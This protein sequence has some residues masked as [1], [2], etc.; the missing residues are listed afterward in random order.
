MGEQLSTDTILACLLPLSLFM[1]GLAWLGKPSL[2]FQGVL[3]IIKG[4]RPVAFGHYFSL[5]RAVVSYDQYLDMSAAELA[6]MRNSYGKLG[7]VHK[8]VGYELGYPRKLDKLKATFEANEKVTRG[9]GKCAR[10]AFPELRKSRITGDGDLARVR[11]TLKHFI[12]DWSAEGAS[13]REIIFQPILNALRQVEGDQRV[14]A[15]VLVPGG[16]LCRLAWDIS[17]LGFDTT[18][19]EMSYFMTLAFRFLCSPSYTSRTDQHILHPYSYWF[20]HQRDTEKVLRG[21]SFPDSIP[22]LSS[23]MQLVEG[24]FLEHRAPAGGYDYVVTLFFIDTSLNVIST[25]E[26]IY[27]LL[28]PG[29]HWINLG[30]LLWPGGSQAR[31]ELSLD[32]VL[33][34]AAMIGFKIKDEDAPEVER[35]KT[36]P[37]EYTADKH[38]MMKWIY[39]A[40]FW[41]A[42][43]PV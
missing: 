15:K 17:E 34:L 11:E 22:N 6:A 25:L 43:K 18:A 39:Q 2:S 16:G 27:S 10:E 8:R 24:D 35:R 30:P 13:E 40:E 23:R 1:I 38:A 41:V 42:S 20:S 3:D 33:S 29:G 14:G 28:R 26:H 4:T 31:V 36:V 19:V 7:R 9:I 37:C 21:V 12:R 5:E 32:E